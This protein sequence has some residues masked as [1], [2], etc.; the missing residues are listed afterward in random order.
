LRAVA[1]RVP[2]LPSAA[3]VVELTVGLDVEVVSD[4]MPASCRGRVA[5]ICRVRVLPLRVG[6]A[7]DQPVGGFI[8]K[9]LTLGFYVPT[10]I[11][12]KRFGR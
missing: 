3:E 2:G 11:H 4:V 10:A 5:A 8:V 12:Q 6:A 1:V 9:E 7:G